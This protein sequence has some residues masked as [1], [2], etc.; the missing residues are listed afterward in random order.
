MHIEILGNLGNGA[1]VSTPQEGDECIE[2]IG[3]CGGH[4]SK[5]GFIGD[6]LCHYSVYHC[7][8]VNDDDAQEVEMSSETVTIELVRFRL[9]PNVSQAQ[10]VAA[11]RESQVFLGAQDGWIS[12]RV[13]APAEHADEWMDC[14]TWSDAALAKAAAKRAMSAPEMAALMGAIEVSSLVME[15]RPG[16]RFDGEAA[17]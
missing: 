6:S 4:G 9:K 1:A 14:V 16:L 15:H 5:V 12:R 7:C 8:H 11:I 3:T 13:V 2:S 10:C 17:Q